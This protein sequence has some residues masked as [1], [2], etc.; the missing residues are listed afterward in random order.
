MVYFSG[1]EGSP[2]YKQGPRI[3]PEDLHRGC[4]WPQQGVLALLVGG[5]GEGGGRC[6]ILVCTRSSI[7]PYSI[8]LSCTTI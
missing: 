5:A 6:H 2:A 8:A 4:G 7:Q 1:A 3:L